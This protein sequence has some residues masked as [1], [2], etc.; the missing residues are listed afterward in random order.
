M[1]FYGLLIGFVCV[2][3]SAVSGDIKKMVI[4][5]YDE[6]TERDAA[7]GKV[8]VHIQK[9]AEYEGEAVFASLE[10]EMKESIVADVKWY[11]W[12]SIPVYFMDGGGK[13]LFGLE[14][15]PMTKPHGGFRKIGI[16][17]IDGKVF[18]EKELPGRPATSFHTLRG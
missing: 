5:R 18:A 7:S 6:A 4:G 2:A 13:L 3:Q 10:K 15:W 14:Y 11:M 1:K 12:G 8:T 16:S 9:V 17:K